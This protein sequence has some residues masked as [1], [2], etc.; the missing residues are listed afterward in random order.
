MESR[1]KSF[2]DGNQENEGRTYDVGILDV[3]S[4]T[5]LFFNHN[6]EIAESETK[7][8]ETQM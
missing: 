6:V 7:K 4:F 8:T 5:K 2:V 1:G 3:D